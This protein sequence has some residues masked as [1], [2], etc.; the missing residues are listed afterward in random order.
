M[1]EPLT[2][3]LYFFEMWFHFLIFSTG[4]VIFWLRNW[5]NTMNISWALLLLL[6]WCFSTRA[7]VATVLNIHPCISSRLRVEC[8]MVSQNGKN[9]VIC[10][11][12]LRLPWSLQRCSTQY[13]GYIIHEPKGWVSSTAAPLLTYVINSL[14]PDDIHMRWEIL[15]NNDSASEWAIKFNALFSDI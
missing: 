13:T 5:S 15:V 10:V 3:C 11:V 4:K 7:A 2:I 9:T 6:A 1:F 8:E 14:P 12:L